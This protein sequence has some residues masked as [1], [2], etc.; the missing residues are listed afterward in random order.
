MKD[1][2]TST[3][4]SIFELDLINQ[5]SELQKGD[6][7]KEG[8]FIMVESDFVNSSFKID[9]KND[10]R[11]IRVCHVYDGDHNNYDCYNPSVLKEN[12]GL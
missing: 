7:T 11:F 8:V 10:E 2:D 1:I 6:I 5:Y 4:F 12:L 3:N 9:R